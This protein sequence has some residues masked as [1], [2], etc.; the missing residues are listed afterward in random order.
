VRDTTGRALIVSEG[1]HEGAARDVPALL[2][3][4]AAEIGAAWGPPAGRAILTAAA[5]RWD[6]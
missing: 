2:D 6:F 4:L 1:L 5:P 3:A